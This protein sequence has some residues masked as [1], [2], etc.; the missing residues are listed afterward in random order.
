MDRLGSFSGRAG[1]G[2]RR[3]KKELGR[4]PLE[5]AFTIRPRLNVKKAQKIV[6]IF[7]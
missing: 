3:K 6:C 1:K 5:V 7:L 2:I 4:L